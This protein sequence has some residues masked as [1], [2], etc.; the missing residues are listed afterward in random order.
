MAVEATLVIN[1]FV[2]KVR[3][4]TPKLLT[5]K[6]IFRLENTKKPFHEQ[7]PRVVFTCCQCQ[8]QCSLITHRA[9]RDTAYQLGFASVKDSDFI[10]F[11]DAAEHVFDTTNYYIE[12]VAQ[13][14]KMA[15]WV[16]IPSLNPG[17]QYG[18]FK[19]HF[20]GVTVCAVPAEPGQ[21]ICRECD[22]TLSKTGK[23]KHVWSH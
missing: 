18:L 22:Q 17:E 23:M 16:T 4:R 12:I 10:A 6:T 11:R 7:I 13:L 3:C 1:D 2:L 8:Q 9:I 14:P 20:V 19:G 21:C 15:C 5:I